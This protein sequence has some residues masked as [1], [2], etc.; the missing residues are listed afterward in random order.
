[1]KADK[2]NLSILHG[3][4]D[5]GKQEKGFSKGQQSET[6]VIQENSHGE[7]IITRAHVLEKQLYV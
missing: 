3:I 4:K 5:K 7:I 1:M 6:R 2:E